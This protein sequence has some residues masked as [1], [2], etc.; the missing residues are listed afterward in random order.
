MPSI[1][2]VDAMLQAGKALAADGVIL[3]WGWAAFRAIL[4]KKARGAYHQCRC[5]AI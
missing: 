4:E 1:A 2:S 3:V 5:S